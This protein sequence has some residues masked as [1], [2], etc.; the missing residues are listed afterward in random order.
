MPLLW[1][2]A[3][4]R[5]PLITAIVAGSIAAGGVSAARLVEGG[6][7]PERVPAL[8]APRTWRPDAPSPRALG[9]TAAYFKALGISAR[10]APVEVEVAKPA[11]ECESKAS[12][13][14]ARRGSPAPAAVPIDS[15]H[16]IT[17]R[18]PQELIGTVSVRTSLLIASRSE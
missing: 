13:R 3:L 16:L 5:T 9:L 17:A 10:E 4:K 12:D 1:T 18:A 2:R 14:L 15:S 6:A 11:A 7:P 8:S